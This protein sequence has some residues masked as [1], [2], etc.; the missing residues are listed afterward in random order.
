MSLSHHFQLSPEQIRTIIFYNWKIG[1][2]YKDRHARLMQAWGSNA[3]S[4]HTVFNC[5]RE[6]QRNKFSVQDVPR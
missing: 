5:F 1:L 2:T 3:P 6:F 4:H